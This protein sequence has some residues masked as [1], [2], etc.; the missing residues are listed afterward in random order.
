MRIPKG[1]VKEFIPKTIQRGYDNNGLATYATQSGLNMRGVVQAGFNKV[2][3]KVH[4]LSVNAVYE[5]NT[6]KY[7]T[8]NQEYSQFNTDLGWEG[9]YDAKSGNHVKSPGVSYEKIAMLS[10]VL[11]ANYSYKG[12]YLLKASMR[13]D[14]SSNSALI[15]VGDFPVRS[16]GLESFR[17]RIF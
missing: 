16:I 2:F 15:I 11:M 14:G 6:N 13:A 1:E 10:G 17:R 3:N 4:S 8:F 7:E 9:I 12:R 5:A